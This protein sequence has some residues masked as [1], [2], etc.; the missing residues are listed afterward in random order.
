VAYSYFRDDS[1]F[2]VIAFT[3]D[4]DFI[5]EDKFLGLPNVPFDHLQE[6]YPP[7]EH[8]MF[9]AVGYAQTN[10]IREEKS[11]HSKENGYKLATYI[12][13]R[14]V[15]MT[16]VRV[17][18]NCSIGA[19][20]AV[21]PFAEIGNNC[22]IR[23]NVFIGHEVKIGDNC[24]VAA[25]AVVGGGA[26]VGNNCILGLNAAIR[27]ETLIAREC[28]IGA[29]ITMLHDTEVGEVYM[30]KYGQKLPFTSKQL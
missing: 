18:E 21:Q 20:V 25:G 15:L 7:T 26:R 4:E 6:I 1:P 5:Q 12:S 23:E 14:S 19:N 30:S 10:K 8:Y 28:V 22:I 9:V 24:F 29:G 2:E 17:G 27:E 16:D 11:G 3:S 13:S